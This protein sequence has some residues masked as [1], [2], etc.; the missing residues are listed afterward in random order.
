MWMLGAKTSFL[1][2]LRGSYKSFTSKVILW[3]SGKI[4]L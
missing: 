4:C 2:G 1:E 3:G